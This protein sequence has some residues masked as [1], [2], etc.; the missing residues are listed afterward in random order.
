M[1]GDR[2]GVVSEKMFCLTG[3]AKYAAAFE[4]ALYNGIL[5]GESLSGDEFFYVN[6]L[7]MQLDKTRYNAAFSGWR[8]AAPDR[9]ARKTFLLFVLP[10]EFVPLYRAARRVSLVRRREQRRKF[11]DV[12]AADFFLP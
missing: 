4:R 10:A 7:E 5:A 2:H 12:G 3:K 6:P 11:G 9:F 8:E 1:R